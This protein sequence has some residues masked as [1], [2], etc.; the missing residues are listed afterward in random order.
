[1]NAFMRTRIRNVQTDTSEYK[2]DY[3]HLFQ[4]KNYQLLTQKPIK[5]SVCYSKFKI[6][7]I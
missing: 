4:R 5:V 1:M 3:Y 6:T 7:T 2:V